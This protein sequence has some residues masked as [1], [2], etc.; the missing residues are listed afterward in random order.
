[1]SRFLFLLKTFSL[2]FLTSLPAQG[3]NPVSGKQNLCRTQA[4]FAEGAGQMPAPI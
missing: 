1:M 3:K 4:V 2:S